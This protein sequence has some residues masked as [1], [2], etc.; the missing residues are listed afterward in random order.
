MQVPILQT[1][2]TRVIK[3]SKQQEKK[4]PNR[5]NAG[6][7]A[8]PHP[9]ELAQ[10]APQELFAEQL[11]LPQDFCQDMEK[12]NKLLVDNFG[13][14]DCFGSN[15]SFLHVEELEAAQQQFMANLEAL[16]TSST[17][18]PNPGGTVGKKLRAAALVKA[19]EWLLQPP[20]NA[21]QGAVKALW[22]EV[23]DEL[24]FLSADWKCSEED[25]IHW[26]NR[27]LRAILAGHKRC[28]LKAPV[29]VDV[30]QNPNC[31]GP[32]LWLPA[33]CWKAAAHVI[34]GE[35]PCDEAASNLDSPSTSPKERQSL[36][37]SSI[38]RGGR[39]A[40]HCTHQA[41]PST[42]VPK[43]TMRCCED[44]RDRTRDI[45]TSELAPKP[46]GPTPPIIMLQPF[47]ATPYLLTEWWFYPIK[48]S[49]ILLVD[50]GR[51]SS[52][53]SPSAESRTYIHVVWVIYRLSKAFRLAVN[54]LVMNIALSQA[55]VPAYA[56]AALRRK[57]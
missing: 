38:Q 49:P 55:D 33:E 11:Q 43:G 51:N 40:T 28:N 27:F 53:L 36:S 4:R 22:K 9:E 5:C 41:R 30:P 26:R 46:A 15:K 7:A 21:P 25:A 8:C 54:K 2:S 48:R 16:P 20:P 10:V 1:Q 52:R 19:E 39:A 37:R 32:E 35:W 17:N 18:R 56:L 3:E 44:D 31:Q 14:A 29:Q 47:S 50:L 13:D 6:G 24:R 42:F 34:G 12:Y 57:Y 45:C 23:V